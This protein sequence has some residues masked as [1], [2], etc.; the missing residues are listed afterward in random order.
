MAAKALALLWMRAS[1]GGFV[2]R[3]CPRYVCSAACGSAAFRTAATSARKEGLLASSSQVEGASP[4]P[5]PSPSP[6][7]SASMPSPPPASSSGRPFVKYSTAR[8][9]FM[10]AA[11]MAA[12]T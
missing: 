2:S 8:S 1:C 11:R 10:K 7:P 12:M 4:S 6:P 3:I 9:A 5:S